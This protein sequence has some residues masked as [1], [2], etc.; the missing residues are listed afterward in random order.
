[1]MTVMNP[2]A[3]RPSFLRDEGAQNSI[4]KPAEALPQA[5]DTDLAAKGYAGKLFRSL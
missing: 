1:M 2:P 5:S 4:N 3:W